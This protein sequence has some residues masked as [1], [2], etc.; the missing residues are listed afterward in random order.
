MLFNLITLVKCFH[1]LLIETMN[2]WPYRQEKRLFEI[3]F[4]A[5]LPPSPQKVLRFLY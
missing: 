4:P 2:L 3:A 1:A 5:N